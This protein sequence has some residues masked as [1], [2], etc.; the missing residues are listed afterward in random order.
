MLIQPSDFAS[1]VDTGDAYDLSWSHSSA[2]VEERMMLGWWRQNA[3]TAELVRLAQGFGI[4]QPMLTR[5]LADAEQSAAVGITVNRSLTSFRL[6]THSLNDQTPDIGQRVFCGY[7]ALS[8][9][10]VRVDD[11]RFQGDLRDPD[12][13]S[14]ARENTFQPAWLENALSKTSDAHPIPL[15]TILNGARSSWLATLRHHDI[16]AGAVLGS[17][18]ARMKLL[19][20]AGGTDVSK[21]EFSTFYL[22][23]S[24]DGIRSL[25]GL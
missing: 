12:L 18:F 14:I 9:G 8:D 22:R 23:S 21:G 7:K 19:H 25:L 4:P 16:D 3:P 11:Y 15:I 2:G 24:P 17:D 10:Q 20:L 6:Y 5:W 13:L 1:I